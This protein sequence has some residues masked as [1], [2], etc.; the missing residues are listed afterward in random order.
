MTLPRYCY[1]DYSPKP[2]AVYT[3][4]EEE[5]DDLVASLAPGCVTTISLFSL[6]CL[7]PPCRLKA[8]F[9]SYPTRSPKGFDLEWVFYF[10]RKPGGG[11]VA[12]EKKVAVVQVADR[13]GTI[14]VL[15]VSAMARE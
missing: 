9:H 1:K 2:I 3:R 14:L 4:H 11:S 13:R 12:V 10:T 7:Y 15:Q 6:F 8:Y 5:A